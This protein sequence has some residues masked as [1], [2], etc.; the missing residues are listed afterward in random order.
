MSIPFMPQMSSVPPSISPFHVAPFDPTSEPLLW[1]SPSPMPPTDPYHQ[2]HVGHTIEDVLMS[3]VHQHESHSQR[4]QE[5]E[6]AQLPPCSCHGQI[7]SPLQPCRSLPPDYAARLVTLEQQVASIIHTPQAMEE[8]W[9]Q[10]CR[11]LYTY[12]PPPPPPSA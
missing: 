7:P 8:D 12:F 2:F 5:L 11:L 4:L 3:F 6:K 1:S 9:L 10:L